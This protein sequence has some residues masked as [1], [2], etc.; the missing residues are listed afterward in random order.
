M[1]LY[2]S[3]HIDG[4]FSPRDINRSGSVL[5][6]SL[7]TLTGWNAGQLDSPGRGELAWAYFWSSGI[8]VFMMA[9]Q[10]TDSSF[11]CR[12]EAAALTCEFA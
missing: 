11:G 5:I 9:A 7:L 12:V 2:D 4:I 1:P 3:R 10:P 8:A 6:H